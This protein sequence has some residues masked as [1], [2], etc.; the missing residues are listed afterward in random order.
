MLRP[1]TVEAIGW[2]LQRYEATADDRGWDVDPELI[3]VFESALPQNGRPIEIETFPL[4]SDTWHMPDPTRPGHKLPST[5]VLQAIAST[6]AA[7]APAWLSEWLHFDNRVF[8]SF[9]FLFEG[10]Q[11]SP[12]PGYKLGDL[13]ATPA[14]AEHEVRIIAAY[15]TDGRYYQVRRIRGDDGSTAYRLNDPPESTR[16][17]NIVA[18]LAHLV[19]IARPL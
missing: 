4:G 5:F 11:T 18:A 14:M 10:W 15:D 3:A 13:R 8:A 6:L 2:A 19:D 12:Y 16:E 1:E 7:E 17:T 9:G